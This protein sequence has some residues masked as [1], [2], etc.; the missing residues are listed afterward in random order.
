MEEKIKIKCSTQKTE[1]LQ[2]YFSCKQNYSNILD[3][4]SFQLNS[5]SKS[6]SLCELENK[7]L[8]SKPIC[9]IKNYIKS[10]YENILDI[11]LLFANPKFKDIDRAAM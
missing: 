1:N 5:L 2:Q 3:R 11:H 7:L 4:Q 10:K 6:K 8:H 9:L